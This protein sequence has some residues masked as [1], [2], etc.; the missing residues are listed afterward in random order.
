MGKQAMGVYTSNFQKRIDT[1]GHILYYPNKPM[2]QTR[3]EITF[4]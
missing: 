2:V 1:L 3:L 4:I